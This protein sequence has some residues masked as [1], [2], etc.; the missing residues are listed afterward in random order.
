MDPSLERSAGNRAVMSALR[1]DRKIEVRDVGRGEQ[2]GFARVPE[3]I[4]RLNGLSPSLT[5]RL[6]GRELVFEQTPDSTPTNF[7]SQLMAL[8]NQ[9]AVLPMRMTNRHGLLGD[10]ASGFHDSVDGDAFTSGYVDID[11]LL[12]GDDLGFQMLL[13]H[14]LTERAATSNYARRIGTD[15]SEAE[16]NR[17]HSLGIEAEAEILRAF[18]GDPSIRIV[19]DS[20]SVTVRRVFRNS[21]GDRIRRRIRLGRGEET[22]VNASSVDVVTAGNIATTPEDYLARPSASAPRPRSS[23]SASGARPSTAR[24]VAA[25]PPRD[26]LYSARH[27]RRRVRVRD[28]LRGRAARRARPRDPG[29]ARGARRRSLRAPRDPRSTSPSRRARGRGR[30]EELE[31]PGYEVVGFEATGEEEPWAI[32]ASRDLRVD[33]DNVTGFRSHFHDLAE[34]HGGEFDGWEAAED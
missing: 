7:E 2:S 22:G 25:C 12:V 26:R 24:V 30:R 10:K 20:P 28:P 32:R 19:A 23:A 16:F 11:D 21:R 34:R 29:D 6:E 18:F 33:R 3:F 1:I 15:F 27:G 17:G 13:V 9:E 31:E 4:E 14:F 5:W 8:V